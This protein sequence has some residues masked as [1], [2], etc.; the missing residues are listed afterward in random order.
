M[1]KL[2][3]DV[4]VGLE[5]MCIAGVARDH[6]GKVIRVDTS[7]LENSDALCGEAAACCLAVSMAMD[8]GYIYYCGE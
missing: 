1:I 3:C 7:R 8:L 4:R 2:N 6:L 5:S